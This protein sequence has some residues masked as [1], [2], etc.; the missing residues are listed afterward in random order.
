MKLFLLY[1]N[2]ANP[3]A[4]PSLKA[5]SI[6]SSRRHLDAK[7]KNL[8]LSAKNLADYSFKS[9]VEDFSHYV[10]LIFRYSKSF[11]GSLFGMHLSCGACLW[12]I[13]LV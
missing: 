3:T 5:T 9:F 13:L 7:S 2:P 10:S 8:F 4:R 12:S 1:C 11:A 6:L